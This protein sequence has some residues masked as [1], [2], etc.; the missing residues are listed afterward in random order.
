MIIL[1][2]KKMNEIQRNRKRRKKK[3]NKHRNEYSKNIQLL[4]VC[5]CFL[6]V[7]GKCNPCQI[8]SPSSCRKSTRRSKT[9]LV[10]VYNYRTVGAPLKLLFA[11]EKIQGKR[12]HG[13][14]PK[15]HHNFKNQVP[16]RMTQ[17]ILKPHFLSEEKLYIGS[18]LCHS[19]CNF[20]QIQDWVLLVSR[21]L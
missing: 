5:K 11:R 15:G 6:L 4:F 13:P 3:L 1:I 2:L 17:F 12:L 14:T 21:L 18:H 8:A 20:I 10:L 19:V 7:K 9:R 16:N